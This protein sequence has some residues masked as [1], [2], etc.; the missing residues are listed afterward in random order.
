MASFEELLPKATA[1]IHGHPRAGQVIGVR[2]AMPGL[3]ARGHGGLCR[4]CQSC[5]HPI[6][7]FG[8]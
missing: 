1:A 3:A 5:R 6:C 4:Q 7:G 2:L 8:R